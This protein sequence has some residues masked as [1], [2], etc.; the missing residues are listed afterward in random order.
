MTNWKMIEDEIPELKVSECGEYM[1]SEPI[2]AKMSE[3][4]MVW[5][6]K[7][8]EGNDDG[9]PW[10]QWYCLLDED[11]VEGITMWCEIPK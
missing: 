3:D 11:C 6:L 9:D 1:T 4:D 7:Y 8:S 10:V 2:L 5:V